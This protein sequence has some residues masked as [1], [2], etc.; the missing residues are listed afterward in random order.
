M[1]Y[2]IIPRIRVQRANALTTPWLISAC[3]VFAATMLGH[4]LG[5]DTGIFPTGV[6]LVHHHADLLAESHLPKGYGNIFPQQYRAASLIDK[7]DYVGQSV[8]LSLQPTSSVDLEVS[9]VMAF[10]AGAPGPGQITSALRQRR[11]AGGLIVGH[12]KVVVCD[13]L[14]GEYGVCRAL[15]TGFWTV[16]QSN[17]LDPAD[18]LG[19]LLNLVYPPTP[20]HPDAELLATDRAAS[21]PDKKAWLTP[22]VLG[23]AMLTAFEQREGVREGV[24]HAF[25]EPLVG[26]VEYRSS[27]HLE[28]ESSTNLFWSGQWHDQDAYVVSQDPT[29]PSV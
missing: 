26:L 13:S 2:L 21:K 1:N 25:A 29:H 20:P 24:P 9:L 11:L 12:G 8:S 19:S 10:A 3:P 14:Y 16:D 28:E 15:R 6:A 7:A 18:R 5:R 23:Y 22:A 4:A 27:R 17:K